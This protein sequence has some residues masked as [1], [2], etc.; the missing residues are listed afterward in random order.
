MNEKELKAVIEI[1]HV[2]VEALC[3]EDVVPKL[4]LRDDIQ[5]TATGHS[6][7]DGLT[8]LLLEGD[9]PLLGFSEEL[10][11][12]DGYMAARL[13]QALSEPWFIFGAFRNQNGKRYYIVLPRTQVPKCFAVLD[14]E[15]LGW[16][17]KILHQF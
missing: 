14:W 3:S 6:E 16:T 13:I 1:A 9:L 7:A 15:I 17:K 5:V 11:H 12:I 2:S 4:N 8:R 10:L